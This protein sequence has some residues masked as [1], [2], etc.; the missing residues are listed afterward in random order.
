[1]AASRSLI[2]AD[3]P[4]S[5]PSVREV[6][7]GRG[8]EVTAARSP[9]RRDD[10]LG[11][12]GEFIATSETA[13]RLSRA[14]RWG[15]TN[16]RHRVTIRLDASAAADS[17]QAAEFARRAERLG[18]LRRVSVSETHLSV[19]I[20][21]ADDNAALVREFFRGIWLEHLAASIVGTVFGDRADR[22]CN[23]RVRLPNGRHAELDAIAA[24][25]GELTWIECKSSPRNVADGAA[26]YGRLRHLLQVTRERT[27]LVVRGIE[28]S[29]AAD[30]SDLHDV[31][32]IWPTMLSAA[33]AQPTN[34]VER[35]TSAFCHGRADQAMSA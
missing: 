12:L 13:D 32:V 24:V 23:A 18:L 35:S 29:L 8:V 22:L 11:R 30:L 2:V 10:V 28:P 17:A 9:S 5:S 25:D 15:L 19:G 33:L 27:L 14:I 16:G 21:V 7:S 3:S 31:S 34:V 26:R 20:D 6:L 4:P 1:M